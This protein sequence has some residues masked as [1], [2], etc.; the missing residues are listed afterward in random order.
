MRSL[1]SDILATLTAHT[2]SIPNVAVREPFDET[3]KT[4][5]MLI[6]YEIVNR[7]YNHGTV[8]GETRTQLSYQ[9]NILTENCIASNGNV[10]SRYQAN[11]ALIGELSDLLS[12]TYKVTRRTITPGLNAGVDVVEQIWRGDCVLDS[13]G[14]S[15]RQ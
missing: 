1:Y 2:F 12:T 4:Y 14:Y 3:P 11:R 5:P 6:V 15:Y 9:V 10:L 8:N 13:A 7:P